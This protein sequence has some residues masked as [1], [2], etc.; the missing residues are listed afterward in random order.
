MYL[1]CGNTASR[2]LRTNSPDT[3]PES[4]LEL[5]LSLHSLEAAFKLT[6][7]PSGPIVI[8]EM[9]KIVFL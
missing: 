3:T 2:M 7:L 9:T 8:L 4:T 6:L 5:G 1:L